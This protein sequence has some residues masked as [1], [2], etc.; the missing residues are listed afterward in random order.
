MLFPIE[1]LLAAYPVMKE[2]MTT[3]RRDGAPDA[4]ADRLANFAEIN[5]A[6][7]LPDYYAAERQ[8]APR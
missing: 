5:Q 7:G 6:L 3:I 1:P 4:M 8:F 2:V